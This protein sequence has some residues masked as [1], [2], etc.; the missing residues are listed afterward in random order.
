MDFGFLNHLTWFDGLSDFV[1]PPNV[2]ISAQINISRL[3]SLCNEEDYRSLFL[4]GWLT[5]SS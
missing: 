4:Q 3:S 5:Q 1:L 2:K